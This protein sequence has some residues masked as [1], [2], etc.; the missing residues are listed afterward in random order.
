MVS[1]PST[2]TVVVSFASTLLFAPRRVAKVL[3][4]PATVTGASTVTG[5]LFS[6]SRACSH[7]P[8]PV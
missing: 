1:L 4:L 2:V 6:S 5:V 8:K 7:V 3:A